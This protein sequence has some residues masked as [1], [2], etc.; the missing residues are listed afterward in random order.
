M[1]N[2]Q[3]MQHLHIRMEREGKEEVRE[4]KVIAR[5]DEC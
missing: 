5:K 1:K 3:D 2:Q 4:V